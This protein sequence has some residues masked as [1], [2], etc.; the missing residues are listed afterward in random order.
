MKIHILSFLLIVFISFQI[1]AQDSLELNSL[2]DELESKEI[3]DIPLLPGNFL[4]T[5]KVFWG[6]KGLM[7][8][9]NSFKLT[10][11]N[12]QKEDPVLRQSLC[13]EHK[14]NLMAPVLVLEE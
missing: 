2:L 1:S 11:E 12:R 10:P 6:K 13:G 9:F 14:D 5:Q 7:R 8:S 4:I 3:K